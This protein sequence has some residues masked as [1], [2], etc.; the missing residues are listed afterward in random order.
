MNSGPAAQVNDLSVFDANYI[1]VWP[2]SQSVL[3]QLL[4]RNSL[5]DVAM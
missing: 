5:L 2:L 3:V 4:I 1:Y